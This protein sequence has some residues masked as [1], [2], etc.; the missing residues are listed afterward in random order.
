MHEQSLVRHLLKQVEAIRLEHGARAVRRVEVTVG[1][2][3]GVEPELL[4]SAFDQLAIGAAVADAELV[5]QQ[6][7][8]LGHCD[9]CDQAHEIHDFRFRCPHCD[10][11]LT[12]TSGDQFELTSVSLAV[13]QPA[14]PS[15]P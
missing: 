11:N 4:A 8:L 1:P 2:L 15:L 12:V 6:V 13:D 3:S 7:P 14:E 9:H 10:H 5:M